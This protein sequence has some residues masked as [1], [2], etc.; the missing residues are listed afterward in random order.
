MLVFRAE[1]E[2]G[3]AVWALAP[4]DADSEDA[5]TASDDDLPLETPIAAALIADHLRRHLLE[6]GWQVQ[7]HVRRTGT[8]WRLVDC[9]SPVD[10]GGDRLDADYPSGSDELEVI[11]RSVVAVHTDIR[12]R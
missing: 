12:R 11:C 1:P 2:E 4:H 10:G 9:L 8:T 3:Q 5:P 6:R 7:A